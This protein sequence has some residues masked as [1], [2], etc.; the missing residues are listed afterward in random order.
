[1]AAEVA[2]CIASR[3]QRKIREVI[4]HFLKHM[5]QQS[6][7]S[8]QVIAVGHVGYAGSHCVS[9]RVFNQQA[10]NTLTYV[11]DCPNGLGFEDKHNFVALRIKAVFLYAVQSH[12]LAFG[13]IHVQRFCILLHII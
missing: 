1:M 11:L 3:R 7:N 13:A 12:G 9:Y 5:F 10:V 4:R 8:V 2:T 6:I